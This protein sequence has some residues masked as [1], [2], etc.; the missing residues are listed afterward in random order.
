MREKYLEYLKSKVKEYCNSEGCYE[1]YIDYDDQ[2]NLEDL[3]ETGEKYKEKGYEKPIDYLEEKYRDRLYF[4]DDDFLNAIIDEMPEE[5][6]NEYDADTFWDD[7]YSVGYNGT[8]LGIEKLLEQSKIDVNLMFATDEERN[9]DMSSILDSYRSIQNESLVEK[10]S[11]DNALTY[12]IHQQGHKVSEIIEDYNYNRQGYSY[13][14]N[15]DFVESITDELA[16]TT[17]DV[18]SELTALVEMN[19]N[20][21]LELIE[22]INEGKENLKLG[23]N[24]MIGIYNEWLGAGGLLDIKCDKDII[25]PTSMIRN[26]QI[27]AI[28]QDYSYTVN[29]VYGLVGEC[30]KD[31]LSYTKESPILAEENMDELVENI[32]NKI[33]QEKEEDYV[34]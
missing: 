15:C 8:D 30:W 28:K 5:L 34:R 10:D 17:C 23:K 22:K 6:K 7:L 16:N 27:D 4:A 13:E 1:M 20:E 19:G 21:Y 14:Y 9:R 26:V 25:I 24:T 29:E 32:N 11:F 2:I 31:T 33:E 3:R 18:Q 12:L